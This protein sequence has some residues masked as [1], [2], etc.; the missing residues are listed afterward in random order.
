MTHDSTL[1][2]RCL[3]VTDPLEA[4]EHCRLNPSNCIVRRN[5][6][7]NLH[8]AVCNLHSHSAVCNEHRSSFVPA[9]HSPPVP[10]VEQFVYHDLQYRRRWDRQCR[11][12]NSQRR[13]ADEQRIFG[14]VADPEDH[15]RKSRQGNE[16][17]G[18]PGLVARSHA[19][20]RRPR[21]IRDR[22][23]AG[24]RLVRRL[25]GRHVRLRS[26]P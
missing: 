12:G 25:R 20:A 3:S 11:T 17:G 6:M 21:S 26:M 19:P 14:G 10:L 1:A 5:L 7:C 8:F 18:L 13:R 16:S 9:P 2:A 15:A 4:R 23:S 22:R 24:R